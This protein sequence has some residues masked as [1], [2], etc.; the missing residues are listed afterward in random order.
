MLHWSHFLS[1]MVL[2]FYCIET[3]LQDHFFKIIPKL[4]NKK[5]YRVIFQDDL[6]K[7]I[8]VSSCKIRN[9]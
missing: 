4:L 2:K 8:V 3:T 9:C 1:Q 5:P 6:E 7:P